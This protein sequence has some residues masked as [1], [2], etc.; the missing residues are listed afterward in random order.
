MRSGSA[1]HCVSSGGSATRRRPTIAHTSLHGSE[2][3]P[4]MLK[5]PG[6][7]LRV[8]N[9]SAPV[10][11]DSC[12]NCRRGSKPNTSGTSGRRSAFENGVVTSSPSTLVK[13]SLVTVTW[14]LSIAKSR[15]NDA[16]SSSERSTRVR[17]RARARH[18]LAEE[19]RV[20]VVGAVGER[21]ALHDHLADRAPGG[22]GRGEQVHRADHVDL[23]ER[24][25]RQLGGVDDE[26]GV[27]DRV[28]LGG[29]HDAVEDR[30]VRSRPARTRCAR[31]AGSGGS[32]SSPTIISTSGMRLEALREVA[33]P[34]RPEPGDEDAHRRYAAPDAAAA[35]Q[36]VVERVL[37]RVADVVGL[38]HHLGARVALLVRGDV[39]VHRRQHADPELRREVD[40]GAERAERE[41]VR[42]HRR[43]RDVE[44]RR[45][46]P[47]LEHDRHRLFVADDRDRDHRHARAHRDLHEA[48]AAEAV[49]LVPVAVRLARSLGALGEH[50]HELAVVV[51]EPE[52]VV[53]VRGDTAEARPHRAHDRD[54]AEEVL[55]EAVH[56]PAQLL[57]DAVH[58]HR[59][60][61]GDRAGVVRDE[62]R[63]ALARDVLEALPL[64]AEPVLV[65]RVVDAAG[66]R[67][68]CARC[69]PHAST[70]PRRMS[71]SWSVRSS[72]SGRG[73]RHRARRD[74]SAASDVVRRARRRAGGLGSAGSAGA[75]AAGS[76]SGAAT[77]RWAG[78]P[79]S[80][81][82]AGTRR[83]N[84]V[85]AVVATRGRTIAEGGQGVRTVPVTIQRSER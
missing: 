84:R 47:A 80:S 20:L 44:Q 21:R 31:A 36:H 77:R 17:G 78:A 53:G 55:R 2:P 76:G 30:V 7:S 1:A 43:V 70:S 35:A 51:Q 85:E 29:P 52:R 74:G 40:A 46:P 19:V 13:R 67:R 45:D 11:S 14:G 64:G 34:E 26:V 81:G 33:A 50:E 39:E 10:T 23:V 72:R 83:G 6:T 15:T 61:G 75:V 8:E 62:Q 9:T 54:R 37:D 4:A 58:D 48:G 18:R 5:T 16:A 63:A 60:V 82:D 3:S 65:H 56:R 32:V 69:G 68:A 25:A 49:E 42:G 28:H 12:V 27:Q 59:R 79:G 73:R 71:R 41:H 66:E 38:V 24:P 22:A 57:L